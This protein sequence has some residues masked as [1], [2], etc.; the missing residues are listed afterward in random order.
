MKTTKNLLL[1]SGSLLCRLSRWQGLIVITRLGVSRR[2]QSTNTPRGRFQG[3][4]V[5]E[6]RQHLT[7][8]RP[9]SGKKRAYSGGDTWEHSPVTKTGPLSGLADFK[10]ER[11]EKPE[12][13]KAELTRMEREEASGEA[14]AAKEDRLRKQRHLVATLSVPFPDVRPLRS[15]RQRGGRTKFDARHTNRS[16]VR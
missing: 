11:Q 16:G 10:A 4:P 1:S 8:F 15:R 3:R 13:A 9:G 7:Q 14:K 5:L 6:K 2:L 12:A